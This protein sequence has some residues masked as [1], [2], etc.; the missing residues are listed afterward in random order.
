MNE[1][2]VGEIY[3]SNRYGDY[4]ILQKIDNYH[5]IIQF[6]KT[7]YV[8][9]ISYASM[10]D[11]TIRD[12]YYPIYYK[13]ACLGVVDLKEHKKEL[14]VWRFMIERCYNEKHDN[15]KTYGGIGVRVCDEWLCFE[16][17]LKD[18]CKIKG[19][20]KTKFENKEIVLDKDMDFDLSGTKVY[21]L[22]YCR[23]VK[24]KDN[25]QEMLTRRKQTTSSR[26]VGVTKLKDGKW[27]ASIS[28]K[29]KNVYIGRYETEEEAYEAYKKK[30]SELYEIVE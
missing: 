5:Y 22:K 27:Q 24:Q 12:P 30:K 29:R 26:Y 11:G 13:V 19:Y 25:F 4:R 16:N 15:Y 7:G 9:K 10:K 1:F 23:F 18:I 17:F 6:A 20:D 3:S 28:Y 14:N 2:K 8:K 21:C